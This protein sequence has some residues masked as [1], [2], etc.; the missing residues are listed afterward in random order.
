MDGCQLDHQCACC[1]D[2]LIF[3]RRSWMVVR[4]SLATMNTDGCAAEH[5]HTEIAICNQ[6]ILGGR[7]GCL[8]TLLEQQHDDAQ[9][10]Q[11]ME[12]VA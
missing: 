6:C 9:H 4:V 3:P 8:N 10:P 12:H 5:G 2:G 11:L 1:G 7:L